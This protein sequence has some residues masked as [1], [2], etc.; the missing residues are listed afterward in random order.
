ML[1]TD[2]EE[3]ANPRKYDVVKWKP[4]GQFYIPPVERRKQKTKIKSS[5]VEEF[6]SVGIIEIPRWSF[7]PSLHF[8]CQTM[9]L[10]LKK[11]R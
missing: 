10:N 7:L 11:V 1:F 4:D 3:W 6:F 2:L 9:G 8:V 5:V